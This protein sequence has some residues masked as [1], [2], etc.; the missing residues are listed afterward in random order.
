M[1]RCQRN[2]CKYKILNGHLGEDGSN[3]DYACMENRTRREAIYMLYGKVT[4]KNYDPANCPL[5]IS[6]QKQEHKSPAWFRSDGN[7]LINSGFL[8]C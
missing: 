5:Y 8:Y 3:C 6:V 1:G 2:D 4:E 7:N